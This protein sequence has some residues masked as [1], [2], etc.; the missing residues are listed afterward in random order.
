MFSAWRE[1]LTETSVELLGEQS[2]GRPHRVTGVYYDH[3]KLVL[4]VFHKLCSI[5]KPK[6]VSNLLF[7]QR[8]NCDLT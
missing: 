8:N 2:V 7:F 4:V 6:I 1:T 5:L 3:I